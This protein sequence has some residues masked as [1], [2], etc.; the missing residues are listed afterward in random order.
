LERNLSQC[1]F[2]HHKS[3]KNWPESKR[4]PPCGVGLRPKLLIKA[5]KLLVG[6][7]VTNG[8]RNGESTC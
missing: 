4:R 7:L 2:V 6:Q 1:H 5:H 3:H 8:I